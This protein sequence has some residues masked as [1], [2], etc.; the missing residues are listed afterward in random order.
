[1]AAPDAVL[2]FWFGPDRTDLAA[3]DARHA[4]WFTPDP[5]F[6]EAIRTR[7]GDL[8]WRARTGALD[9]WTLRPEGRLA[10]IIVLDQ[11]TRQVHRGSARAFENDTRALAVCIDG[12][13]QQVDRALTLFER[14]FFYLPLEHSELIEDQDR[15]VACYERLVE[16]T[17]P[18][19]Q[20]RARSFLAYAKEHRDLV[21]RFGR[22]PHRNAVLG[23]DDTPEERAYLETGGKRYGQG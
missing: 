11:F 14:A 20:R 9:A 2:D 8:I 5:D 21:Q 19:W 16:D 23:R 17:S 10:L 12:I 1:M 6:D 15:S 4:L 22:F 18:L 13:D 7:F 3:V